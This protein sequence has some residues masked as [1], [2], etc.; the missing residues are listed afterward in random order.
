MIQRKDEIVNVFMTFFQNKHDYYNIIKLWSA[1]KKYGN[2]QNDQATAKYVDALINATND[3]FALK[4]IDN[5]F[6][7]QVTPINII[8]HIRT[9]FPNEWNKHIVSTT[10]IKTKYQLI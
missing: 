4:Q 1:T 5:V 2:A 8:E 10:K 7:S 3:F 6:Y 9:Q